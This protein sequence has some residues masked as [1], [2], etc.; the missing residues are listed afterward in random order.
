M[1]TSPHQ[2]LSLGYLVELHRVKENQVRGELRV[3][4]QVSL[5]GQQMRLRFQKQI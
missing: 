3:G 4:R 5:H 2:L 1:I